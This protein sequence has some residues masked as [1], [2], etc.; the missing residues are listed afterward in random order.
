MSEVVLSVLH[1]TR[2]PMM[3]VEMMK[4]WL[5]KASRPERVEYIFGID[6]DDAESINLLSDFNVTVSEPGGACVG[7][8]NACAKIS[9]GEILV[10]SSDDL[11]PPQD[12][13]AQIV[14]K[15]WDVDKEIALHVDDGCRDDA[16]MA[17]VVMTRVRYQKLGYFVHPA[18]KSVFADCWHTFISH[19]DEV[20]VD[21]R[22]IKFDHRH[23]VFGK[24][25]WDDVY[26][27]QNSEER[28]KE[29]EKIF[30]QLVEETIREYEEKGL[31]KKGG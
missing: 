22:D 18:F 30:N 6:P 24:N 3:A 16:L 27:E 26:R 17:I 31:L 14:K 7:A 10:L 8:T 13:D 11:Y 28:S 4:D 5:S 2:R 19:L 15:V 1:P 29:G 21:A 25:E 20:R 12:W 23:P 9:K